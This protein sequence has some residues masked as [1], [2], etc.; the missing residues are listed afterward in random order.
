VKQNEAMGYAYGIL[1]FR[2]RQPSRCWFRER[3]GWDM[4]GIDLANIGVVSDG[5]TKGY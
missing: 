4:D 3:I 2:M 5:K 1:I